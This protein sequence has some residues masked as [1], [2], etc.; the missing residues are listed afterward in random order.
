MAILLCIFFI[1]PFISI[2]LSVT[3]GLSLHD[4]VHLIF[5]KKCIHIFFRYFIIYFK[6]DYIER[7][8]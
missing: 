6:T 5:S 4:Y 2:L 3:E 7:L 8:N 1:K